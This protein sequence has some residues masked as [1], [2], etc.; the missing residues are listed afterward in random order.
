MHPS[1]A[2]V[3]SVATPVTRVTARARDRRR[4]IAA[5]HHNELVA[6]WVA[7]WVPPSAPWVSWECVG[8]RETGLRWDAHGAQY[9]SA[10]GMLNQAVRD[11]ADSPASA[12]RILAGTASSQEEIRAAWRETLA[13]GPGA[14]APSTV[15]ACT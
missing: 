15:A 3:A 9:S 12:A 1:V 8:I 13:F 7:A 11:R 4:W 14:W 10:F 6:W 2:L 5:V